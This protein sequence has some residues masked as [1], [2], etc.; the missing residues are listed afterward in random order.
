MKDRNTYHLLG[1]GTHNSYKVLY[2]L[3]ALGAEYTFKILDLAKGEQ[4]KPDIIQ[5]NPH[6]RVPILQYVTKNN[7]ER[8]LYESGAICR[9]L[10]TNENSGLYPTDPT[11]R[12]VADQW[13]DTFSCHLGAHIA[14]IYFEKIIK[15]LARLG[16]PDDETINRAISRAKQE[17]NTLNGWLEENNYLCGTNLTIADFFAFAYIEQTKAIE[18]SIDEHANILR[19]KEAIEKTPAVK[20]GRSRM[21]QALAEF[22]DSQ[23]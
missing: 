18:F 10:A 17:L 7:E 13:L 15:Q 2:V 14:A 23:K 12:A 3:E 21:N 20:N 22:K 4:F 1:Y 19:W 16:P 6:A 11:A 8:S 9:F 5:Q